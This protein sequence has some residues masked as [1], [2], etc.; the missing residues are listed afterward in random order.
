LPWAR[1]GLALRVHLLGHAGRFLREDDLHVGGDVAERVPLLVKLEILRGVLRWGKR[2]VRDRAD[3]GGLLLAV[4][5]E[6][7]A[8]HLDVGVGVGAVAEAGVFAEGVG[9]AVEAD[10]ALPGFDEVQQRVLA[11]LGHGGVAVLAAGLLEVAGG[12]EGDDVVLS[13]VVGREDGAVLGGG[14]VEA[15]LLAEVDEDAFGVGELVGLGSLDARV[16][17]AGGLGEEEDL[18]GLAV[19]GA[20]VADREE[21]RRRERRRHGRHVLHRLPPGHAFAA[22]AHGPSSF[23]AW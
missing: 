13:E 22:H 3:L 1:V 18:A 5:V 23:R 19:G 11:A 9:G 7:A 4:A 15:V 6:L 10:E 21:R 14:D 16:L 12:V 17:E 20:G 2:G 8:D